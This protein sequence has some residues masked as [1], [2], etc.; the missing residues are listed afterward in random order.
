M[1]N[2]TLLSDA[3]QFYQNIGYSY[4][5]VPWCVDKKVLD[6]T[7]PPHITPNYYQDNKY[8]VGSAE[9]SFLQLRLDNKLPDGKYVAISPCF[10][11]EVED[12]F[13]KKYFMKVE[14]IQISSST[15]NNKDVLHVMNHANLFFNQYTE[16]CI[17]IVETNIGF[18]LAIDDI[19]IGSYGIRSYFDNNKF[20]WIYGTGLAEPRFSQL[21]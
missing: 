15:F 14:L 7:I 3:L 4:I 6:I 5:E 17:N 19:E 1:I 9:Q 16:K 20:N 18:D 2:Y 12:D 10:R 13:H 8:F 11:D 21:K